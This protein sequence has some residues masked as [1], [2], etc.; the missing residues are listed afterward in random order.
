MSCRLRLPSASLQMVVGIPSELWSQLWRIMWISLGVF[1][2][3][4]KQSCLI[5]FHFCS[6]L[7]HL[8]AT[9]I[10][11]VSSSGGVAFA[12]FRRS[13]NL[14]SVMGHTSY[15]WASGGSLLPRGHGSWPVVEIGGLY[16]VVVSL[17]LGRE[18]KLSPLGGVTGLMTQVE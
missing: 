17:P 11:C 12:L 1:S 9:I 10:L 5:L 7:V 3:I 14:L 8:N 18:E 4:G 6:T 16:R 2:L 13:W 15:C